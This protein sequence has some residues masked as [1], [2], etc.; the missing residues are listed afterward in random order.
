M[1][2]GWKIEVR[3][4]GDVLSSGSGDYPAVCQ[5]KSGASS[6]SVTRP[7]PDGGADRATWMTSSTPILAPTYVARNVQ[8][9]VNY[10]K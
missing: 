9:M 4:N 10:R 5:V 7:P 6:C 3:H 2:K 8:I 1:P